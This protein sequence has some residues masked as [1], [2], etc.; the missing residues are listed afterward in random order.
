DNDRS[1][2]CPSTAPRALLARGR[3]VVRHAVR[4]PAKRARPDRS[5]GPRGEGWPTRAPPR[6][7]RRAPHRPE[8]HHR[9]LPPPRPG[10]HPCVPTEPPATTFPL[11]LRSMV[12]ATVNALAARRGIAPLP[13][14]ADDRA[15]AALA[16]ALGSP[17]A[18]QVLRAHAAAAAR[19]TDEQHLL[20]LGLTF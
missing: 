20:E 18:E 3:R 5:S 7:R 4:R 1:D 11:F 16:G 19:R 6:P 10:A 13:K 8:S 12:R 2:N 17:V 9:A 15:V 14:S